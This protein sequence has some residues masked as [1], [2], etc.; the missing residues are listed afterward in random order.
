MSNPKANIS[1]PDGSTRLS[2]VELLRYDDPRM[3]TATFRLDGP[4]LQAASTIDAYKLEELID[5]IRA[6]LAGTKLSAASSFGEL[7]FERQKSGE[8]CVTLCGGP[9]LSGVRA[10]SCGFPASSH[11]VEGF[12]LSLADELIATRRRAD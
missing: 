8:I 1:T 2:L 5:D 3:D 4:E 11:A 6:V 10:W 9:Y 12:A 7:R